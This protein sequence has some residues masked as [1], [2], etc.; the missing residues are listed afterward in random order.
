M[1]IRNSFITNSSSSSFV[2]N[3]SIIS[4]VQEYLLLHHIDVAQHLELNTYCIDREA[5]VITI[6]DN[7]IV[8]S[9]PMDNFDMQ[10]FFR[11]INIEVEDAEWSHS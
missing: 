10:M 4:P 3:R 1:K 8:G 9:T 5:W 6:Q 2:I 11:A 7:T